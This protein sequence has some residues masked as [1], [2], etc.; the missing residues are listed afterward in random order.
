VKTHIHEVITICDMLDE[1]MSAV[2]EMPRKS[3]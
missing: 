3:A 1:A 2:R